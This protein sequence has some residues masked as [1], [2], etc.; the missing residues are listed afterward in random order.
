M[1]RTAAEKKAVM[2]CALVLA[3]GRSERM[4]TQKLLLPLGGKPV[5]TRIVDALQPSPVQ[6]TF[7]VVGREGERIQLALQNRTV[8]FVTNPDFAGDMLGSIRCGL[9]ALPTRCEAVLIV[10]GDQPNLT[11]QLVGELITAFH[12]S[13]RGI[14]VPA[15]AG[16]GGHPV[17]I[18]IRYREELLHQ[19]AGA[20]LRGLLEAHRDDVFR[21]EVPAAAVLEDM[22]TP[23]DY[24]R[25]VR[26]TDLS[27]KSDHRRP[28]ANRRRE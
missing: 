18:S 10:L 3:A 12:Q 16:H 2:I 26:A 20:G 4:G 5:I 15:H 17:L 27:S 24:E 28:D 6:Q 19:F 13:G 7:V 22:D 25:H 11:A 23:E 21:L 9:R 1:A 8:S 14:I